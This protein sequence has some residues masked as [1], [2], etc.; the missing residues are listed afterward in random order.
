MRRHRAGAN[1]YTH[2]LSRP[3]GDDH[4]EPVSTANLDINNYTD[5]FTHACSDIQPDADGY[6]NQYANS[7]S[8]PP[9][10]SLL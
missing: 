8:H 2:R 3:N 1:Q 5:F 10:R 6:L 9:G 7:V 4:P